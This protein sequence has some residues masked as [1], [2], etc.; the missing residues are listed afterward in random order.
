MASADSRKG[1]RRWLAVLAVVAALG[2][3]FAYLGRID[4]NEVGDFKAFQY[5]HD[6]ERAPED[7]SMI[8]RYEIE[9]DPDAVLAVLPKP[10]GGRPPQKGVVYEFT[11]PSGREGRFLYA[12][13]RKRCV[14]MVEGK[15]DALAIRA[16]RRLG[17]R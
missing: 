1:I 7:G 2:A 4:P 10:K 8:D 12:P 14:V 15:P 3:G 9:G 6:Q 17:L 13:N 5:R 11:L 16:L